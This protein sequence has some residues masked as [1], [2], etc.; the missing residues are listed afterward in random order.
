MI[1]EKTK[2]MMLIT[3]CSGIMSVMTILEFFLS[4]TVGTIMG[5]ITLIIIYYAYVKGVWSN[6]EIHNLGL[7]KK[8][9]T[10]RRRI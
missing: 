3:F 2:A 4:I 9:K 5:F 1:E 7:R 6:D 10:L 8:K